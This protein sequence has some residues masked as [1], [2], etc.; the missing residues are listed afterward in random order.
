MSSDPRHILG[1]AAEDQARDYL[2]GQ[3]YQILERNVRYKVGELDIVATEG[4]TL[5]FV[6]V[7]SRSNP[8][9]V[10]PAATVTPRKQR[11]V[12][13][14]AMAYCQDHNI[15]DTMIRFDVVAVLGDKGEIELYKN[16]FEA[17][18]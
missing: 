8:N 14:A 15:K 13:R 10:H 3:G 1:A 7:R 5:V 17:G 11:Q 12:V 18:R 6:E 4:E 16:A 9:Q 2:A